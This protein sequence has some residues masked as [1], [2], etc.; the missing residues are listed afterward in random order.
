MSFQGKRGQKTPTYHVSV[1]T[2]HINLVDPSFQP[3][4]A[5]F[6]QSFTSFITIR[7]IKRLKSNFLVKRD[8]KR[9][10]STK[11]HI[12]KSINCIPK[13]SGRFFIKSRIWHGPLSTLYGQTNRSTGK[14]YHFSAVK[15]G[16]KF[17]N[18]RTS[19]YYFS[20][21]ISFHSRVF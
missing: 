20:R 12:S 9:A 1:T 8:S 17:H 2:G 5:C 14:F 4:K 7:A 21:L 10:R 15:K 18:S 19:L 3:E 16:V 13:F 11:L 6:C